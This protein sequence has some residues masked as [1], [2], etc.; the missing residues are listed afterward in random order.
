MLKSLAHF[1]ARIWVRSKIVSFLILG[2]LIAILVLSWQIFVGL[3]GVLLVLAV[4]YE[5]SKRKSAIIL[6][7]VV[8]LIVIGFTGIP[9]GSSTYTDDGVLVYE[10]RY[11]ALF[12]P[13]RIARRS[14]RS[15][16]NVEALEVKVISLLSSNL[17]AYGADN[18]TLIGQIFRLGSMI[19]N[20]EREQVGTFT[21]VFGWQ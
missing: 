1:L 17:V 9:L 11:F 21:V 2:A 13:K 3:A 5:L 16:Q 15:H 7:L 6:L 18:Y 20:G 12:N 8:G 4:A 14:V 10:G 19:S